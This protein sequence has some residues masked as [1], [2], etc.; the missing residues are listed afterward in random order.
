MQ[1]SGLCIN[2]AI[3]FFLPAMHACSCI[4]A[5]TWNDTDHVGGHYGSDDTPDISTGLQQCEI[6]WYAGWRLS[7]VSKAD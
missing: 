1:E 2:R 4:I 5:Y 7:Q 6:Q 3:Q